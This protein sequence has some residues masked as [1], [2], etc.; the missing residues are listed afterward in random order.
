MINRGKLSILVLT[1]LYFVDS[2]RS[3]GHR[4][5]TVGFN[6]DNYELS[7]DDVKRFTHASER[8]AL[9]QGFDYT[10]SSGTEIDTILKNLP[11]D[12]YPDVIVYHD[13]S[14]PILYI[15]GLEEVPIPTI[16]YSIDIHLHK[17]RHQYFCGLFDKTLVAQK[18]YVSDMTAYC[19]DTQWF[20]L[21]S[22]ISLQPSPVKDIEL[23]FRGSLNPRVNHNRC[24]FFEALALHT[25]I[26]CQSGPFGEVF[27]RSKIVIN[28]TIKADLNFRVFEAMMC[29][30]ML[31][32]PRINNGQNEL[33]IAGQDLVEY[34]EQNIQDALEKITYYLSHEEERAAIASAGREKVIQMHTEEIRAIQFEQHLLNI[35]IS[36]RPKIYSSATYHY[37]MHAKFESWITK[38]PDSAQDA[39]LKTVKYAIFAAIRG[40]GDDMHFLMNVLFCKA[41]LFLNGYEEK[42]VTLLQKLHL[43]YPKNET[44]LFIYLGTLLRCGKEKEAYAHARLFQPQNVVHALEHSTTLLAAIDEKVLLQL[45]SQA[46]TGALINPDM[47]RK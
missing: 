26:D 39:L 22:R 8:S 21:W 30:A 40:E 6:N 19:P 3:Y 41:I 36:R 35:N 18:D 46:E 44:L 25:K 12:F 29:G 16:F 33:F 31:L 13:D 23:C 27:S 38:R 11:G 7:S 37:L 1:K 43:A 28:Q 4:V 17:D 9:L 2:L 45:K 14:N 20:P 42:A 32:T 5:I 47:L 24:K 34:E 10:Y 15:S